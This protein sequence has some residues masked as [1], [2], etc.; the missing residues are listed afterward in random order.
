M[1]KFN[2]GDTVTVRAVAVRT[3]A[4]GKGIT[5]TFTATMEAWSR[6][7]VLT[8]TETI[9]NSWYRLSIGCRWHKSWLTLEKKAKVVK[10]GEEEPNKFILCWVS[11]FNKKPKATE[12]PCL[13]M[14]KRV[15]GGFSTRIGFSWKY[16]TPV[17]KKDLKGILYKGS[18]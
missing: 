1:S 16:A 17:R 12:N 2:V 13:R 6:G 15:D 4:T 10:W 18:L 3:K 8:I 5:D 7:E 11:D 9:N 14:V